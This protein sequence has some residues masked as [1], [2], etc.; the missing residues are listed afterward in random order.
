MNRE[1][2]VAGWAAQE[3]WLNCGDCQT[4]LESVDD[5]A[6]KKTGYWFLD[7]DILTGALHV[8]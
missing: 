3:D 5:T 1:L 8:L 4:A 6:C 2:G 7:G